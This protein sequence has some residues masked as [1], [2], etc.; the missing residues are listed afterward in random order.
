MARRRVFKTRAKCPGICTD[1]APTSNRFAMIGRAVT[2]ENSGNSEVAVCL[3][4]AVVG[5]LDAAVGNQVATAINRGQSFTAVVI[6]A[7]PIYNDDFKQTSAQID[8]QVEYLLERNQP[9]IE[10]PTCWRAGPVESSHVAGSFFTKIAGVTFGGRQRIVP[11]C[12]VGESLRLVRD[13]TNRYDHGA[14]RVVRS[15]GEQLGFIPA[16]VSRGGDPTGLA[17]RMDRGDKF[18]CRIKDL[19]GGGEGRS[20]GVNIEVTEG[21][22]LDN[23]ASTSGAPALLSGGPPRSSLRWLFGAA[24]ALL[25]II[26]VVHYWP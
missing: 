17:F 4:G 3:D 2:L 14:I 16:H 24:A 13:P 11:R 23:V 21:E 15:N 9:A 25:F 19:T 1:L 18:Q 8:I 26:V 22:D 7:Y 12:S 10:A 20:F 6:N 5:H